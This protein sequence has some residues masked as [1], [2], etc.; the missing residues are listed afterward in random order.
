LVWPPLAPLR[1]RKKRKKRKGGRE[2]DANALLLLLLLRDGLRSSLLACLLRLRVGSGWGG[3]GKQP[4]DL[5]HGEQRHALPR[6]EA[7]GDSVPRENWK[8][9]KRAMD[10]VLE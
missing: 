5:E 1:R 9:G 6:A 2:A 10:D 7:S 3:R 4:V 8:L